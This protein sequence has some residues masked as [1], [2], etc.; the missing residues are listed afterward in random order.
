LPYNFLGTFNKSQFDRFVDYARSILLYVDNRIKHLTIEQQRIGFLK[1]S[2]D[3]AGRPI[4][5]STGSPGFVTYIGK[6][7]QAYEILGGD[8]FHDLQVRTKSDPVYYLKGD[9]V[10]TSK[11]MS[12]GEPIP[13]AGL[14]DAVSGN[15]VRGIRQ[16]MDDHLDRFERLER[17]IRRAIDYADQIQDEIDTLNKV[18]QSAE[19]DGSMENL[20]ALV[21][22][23]FSDSSYR[24]ITDDMK[25]DIY[26]KLAYA[27][28]SSYDQG[29]TRR[30]ADGVVVER[31]SEGTVISGGEI[32]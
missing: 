6:L 28:M 5:Y 20:I 29:G 15:A 13:Q 27:P 18:R 11:I 12:N 26:G 23:L 22:S 7:V 19:T 21:N 8:P 9:E 31:G 24:S 10:A 25:S 17:K 32:V 3:P 2:Y 14:A 1:F 4:S 16:W 30:G